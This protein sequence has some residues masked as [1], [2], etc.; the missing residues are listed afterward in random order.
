[1]H[2]GGGFP[3]TV[4]YRSLGGEQ[5]ASSVIRAFMAI[6]YGNSF[7]CD[8]FFRDSSYRDSYIAIV[9]TIAK[10]LGVCSVPQY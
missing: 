10:H 9:P 6:A 1:M 7:Y 8:S 5:C 3:S 2:V 4:A